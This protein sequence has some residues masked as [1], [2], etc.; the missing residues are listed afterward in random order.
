M[1]LLIIQHLVKVVM[2]IP[3]TNNID[4][5]VTSILSIN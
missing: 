2:K 4:V 5:V 3:A 1:P